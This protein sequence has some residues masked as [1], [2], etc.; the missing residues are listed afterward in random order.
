MNCCCW[1]SRPLD[2]QHSFGS[3][4]NLSLPIISPSHCHYCLSSNFLFNSI[5]SHINSNWKYYYE[6]YFSEYFI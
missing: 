5:L 6:D 3:S 2:A 1:N 4:P